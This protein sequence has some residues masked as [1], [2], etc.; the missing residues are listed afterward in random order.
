MCDNPN[1]VGLIVW[2]HKN[3]FNSTMANAVA[4]SALWTDPRVFFYWDS[5][6]TDIG[7]GF[8]M[9]VAWSGCTYAWDISMIYP[10]GVTWTG[11]YPPA[12]YYCI[13][14][15]GCCNTYN[16]INERNQL[17]ALGACYDATGI[18]ENSS[19]LFV[20][21][22][23]PNPVSSTLNI[24]SKN[25]SYAELFS[26]DGK[27]VLETHHAV[28]NVS[29]LSGGIYLVKITSGN[30]TFIRKAVVLR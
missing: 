1:L 25:F 2:I 26:V 13:S 7:Y 23:F 11:T 20:P 22:I 3:G 30:D 17:N 6:A 15:T 4:Q 24:A 10:A 9:Q 19:S 16:I 5:L 12:P 14:K 28:T 27:K 18:E 29:S 8:G 21:A